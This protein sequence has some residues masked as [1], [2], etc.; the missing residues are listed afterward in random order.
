MWLVDSIGFGLFIIVWAALIS[1]WLHGYFTAKLKEDQDKLN[2]W[3][4][5]P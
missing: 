3:K 5:K 4:D 1:W 2:K